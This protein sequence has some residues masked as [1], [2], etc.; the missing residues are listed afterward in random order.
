MAKANYFVQPMKYTGDY[1][2]GIWAGYKYLEQL[3]YAPG[4]HVGV[5]YNRGGGNT[6][7]GDPIKAVANGKVIYVG[8]NDAG[9]FGK[10]IVIEH[11]LDARLKS[12]L[13]TSKLISRYFHL[14]KQL[15]KKGA[16]VKVGQ[17]IGTC[18]NTGTVFAHLHNMIHKPNNRGHFDY[19]RTSTAVLK[20]YYIDPWKTYNKYGKDWYEMEELKKQVAQLKKEAI[21]SK[22]KIV[23]LTSDIK[24]LNEQVIE[25]NNSNGELETALKVEKENHEL[26]RLELAKCTKVADKP[27]TKPVDKPDT[28]P[29]NWLTVLFDLFRRKEK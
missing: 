7:K 18:G 27:T 8:R 17:K 28:K 15:V 25:L 26:T 1:L 10:I 29:T 23:D 19:P 22:N 6:D 2:K 11:T 21:V 16:I 24:K 14:D 12:K 3:G 20:K 5:D 13:G 9:G 4:V